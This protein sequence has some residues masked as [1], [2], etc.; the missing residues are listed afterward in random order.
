MVVRDALV[1]AARTAA[2]VLV[3][4]VAIAGPII[5]ALPEGWEVAGVNVHE[6]TS[7]AVAVIVAISAALVAFVQNVA[8]DNTSFQLPK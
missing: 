7:G 4:V 3:A 6:V 1:R 5:N 8:E 2:Q